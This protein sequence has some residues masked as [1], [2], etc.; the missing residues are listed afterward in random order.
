M[1]KVRLALITSALI[2]ATVAA[3]SSGG[4]ETADKSVDA[5]Q[6]ASQDTAAEV[7]EL[8]ITE[9]P[10]S[11]VDDSL[12]GDKG[13]N[14]TIE[15]GVLTYTSAGSS[16]CKPIIE[17]AVLEGTT[18]TLTRFDYAGKPCTMDY[19]HFK[20]EITRPGG[21]EFPEGTE[22]VLVDPSKLG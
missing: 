3:C 7:V 18:A 2:L 20:Q 11:V 9:I 13:W 8:E 21:G 16:T 15:G 17:T 6:D 12:F 1:N 22:V 19:R 4:N 14:A 10:D 5:S